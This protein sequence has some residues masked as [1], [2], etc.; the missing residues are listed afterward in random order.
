LS[1]ENTN[2]PQKEK[3]KVKSTT[4]ADKL[5]LNSPVIS[6]AVKGL[7]SLALF[8]SSFKSSLMSEA[9]KGLN[10]SALLGSS[11]KSSA[12]SEALKGLNSSAMS[13]AL[14]GL[15]SSAMS[16][17]LKRLNSFAMSEA[18]KGLNSFAMSEALK[19]L[20]SSAMS[21]ALKGLN[22]SA[23]SEALKGLNSFAM[24]EALKG[25]NSSAMSEALK[26]LN[27]SAMSEALKAVSISKELAF[28][29][30]VKI[31]TQLFSIN[32]ER[33]LFVQQIDSNILPV[34]KEYNWFITVSLEEDFISNLSQVI[35][36]PSNKLGISLRHEFI[37]YFSENNFINLIGMVEG[38]EDNPLFKPRMK[39]FRDSVRL[40]KHANSHYNPSI[41]LI[42]TLISQI[43]GIL[44]DYLIQN[45][46][47]F[48]KENK[49]WIWKDKNLN[50]IYNRKNVYEKIFNP[51]V[52]DYSFTGS[53]ISTVSLGIGSDFILNTLFQTAYT[54]QK[55]KK[56]F[57]LSR[58]KIMHGEYLRYGRNDHLY[59]AFL[60]LDFLYGLKN[61]DYN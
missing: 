30:W 21:E 1:E 41:F 7:N 53:S 45:E 24:S 13:E 19:G 58:H 26:G 35:E 60:I 14:K 52:Q 11:F 36:N 40:L 33:I 57:G 27:S 59:R 54:R 12:M 43:D 15:N 5:V 6:E 38:W 16:E 42:P 18:L 17:A 10:S 3:K 49:N 22:S 48:V 46:F 39:I 31:N 44:T 51:T 2:H 55:L 56:P 20:N 29:N 32:N 4:I 34:L 8:E 47:T 23:M 37:N 28:D 50:I 25:L 61:V 9:I